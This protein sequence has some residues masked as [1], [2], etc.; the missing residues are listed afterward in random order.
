M[1]RTENLT[2]R[3]IIEQQFKT[4]K[5]SLFKLTRLASLIITITIS[6]RTNLTYLKHGR[7]LG[8]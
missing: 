7:V 5:N 8:T 2:K 6:R 4:Y 1:C 3:K